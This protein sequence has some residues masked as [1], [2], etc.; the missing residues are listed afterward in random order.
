MTG[1]SCRLSD[2]ALQSSR[3]G[4]GAQGKAPVLC[5][6]EEPAGEDGTGLGG[7]AGQN[8]IHIASS[9]YQ[10]GE[11]AVQANESSAAPSSSRKRHKLSFKTQQSNSA[12]TIKAEPADCAMDVKGLVAKAAADRSHSSQGQ[13]RKIARTIKA[14]PAVQVDRLAAVAAADQTVY[15]EDVDTAAAAAVLS[16][17]S[18]RARGR[19]GINLDNAKG[20]PERLGNKPLRLIIGGNNPSDHAW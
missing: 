4:R 10:G 3:S 5:K 16:D 7:L 8:G 13:Q 20:L 2:D 18:K 11:Q 17:I 6:E 9:A 19:E 15:P 1:D 14:E 12:S